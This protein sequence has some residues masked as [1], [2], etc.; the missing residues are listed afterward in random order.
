MRFMIVV[1]ATKDS[2]AGVLLDAPHADV[3]EARVGRSYA[4]FDAAIVG[5]DSLL[6]QRSLRRRVLE[7]GRVKRATRE[8]AL[9]RE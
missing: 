9:R 2:E 5:D 1:K 6:R 4:P 7:H 3:V 8:G